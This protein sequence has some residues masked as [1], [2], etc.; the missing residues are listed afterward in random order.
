[1]TVRYANLLYADPP[2]SD[3]DRLVACEA[4]VRGLVRALARNAAD[5]YCDRLWGQR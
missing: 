4:A 3:S 1:M 2:E 5:E